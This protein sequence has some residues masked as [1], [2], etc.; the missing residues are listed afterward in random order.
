MSAGSAPM[1][2]KLPEG[3]NVIPTDKKNA[4]VLLPEPQRIERTPDEV[5]RHQELFDDHKKQAWSDKQA[6]SDE[7]DRALLTLSSGTLALS[8][9]F[10]KDIVPLAQATHLPL[11]FTSWILFA[12]CITV[13]LIS[14]RFSMVANDNHLEFA[15]RY[16][17]E[18]DESARGKVHWCTKA[19]P[20]CAYIGGALLIIGFGLTVS[21][22]I[23]NI[24]AGKMTDSDKPKSQIKGQMV[25]DGRSPVGTVASPPTEERGRQPIPVVQGDTL[26]KGRT[27]VPIVT[28]PAKTETQTGGS[29]TGNS[30]GQQ[31]SGGKQ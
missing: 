12:L 16:H 22:A 9:A 7:F 13:T 18:A 4:G 28:V 11:L 3:S 6:G 23:I 10:I 2:E 30:S 21:F 26:E 25:H 17:L 20:W 14:F 5:K 24:K 1:P 31:T 8:L 19:L 15:R 29:S 27:P